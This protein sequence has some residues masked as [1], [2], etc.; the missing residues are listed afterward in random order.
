[1]NRPMRK[2]SLHMVSS[3]TQSLPVLLEVVKAAYQGG[4]DYVHIREK[5]RTAAELADWV[6]QIAAVFPRER[7]I[8]NDRVDVAAA[9]HCGG[10]H[11]AYHS[12]P[13]QAA[14]RVLPPEQWIG[15]SV[16]SWAEA[17]QVAQQEVDYLFYG[18]IY[19]S[20]SKP[21]LAP[22]GTAELAQI[23]GALSLPVIAIGGIRPENVAE[24]MATGCA[25]IAVLS[26]ITSADNPEKAA[27]A[28][29]RALDQKGV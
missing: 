27:S 29:R 28:Y 5:Q 25:G 6:E 22:R 7:I 20:R 4:I 8:V 11:L 3:G 26:G 13:P 18:H 12:L 2:P 16:H 24:V 10:A 15:R 21:D 23:A 14:R 1:M 19:D 9:C 17:V